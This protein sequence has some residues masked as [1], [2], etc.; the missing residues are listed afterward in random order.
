MSYIISG[1]VVYDNI[2]KFNG[3]FEDYIDSTAIKELN[4][5]LPIGNVQRV[6]GGTGGNI[7]NI[8]QQLNKIGG[9]FNQVHSDLVTHIGIDNMEIKN[10]WESQGFKPSLVLQS[11]RFSTASCFIISS[12]NGNQ[13]TSFYAGALKE[14]LPENTLKLLTQGQNI[15]LSPENP[16]NTINIIRKNKNSELYFDPGQN[17]LLFINSY[18]QDLLYALQHIHGLF[19]N[20]YEAIV[21]LK[22][23]SQ[24]YEQDF[25]IEYL[26]DINPTL[27]FVVRTLGSK[28]VN[29]YYKQTSTTAQISLPVAPIDK[30]VDPTGCGDS[31]RAG[32]FNSYFSNGDF[33]ESL[34]KGTLVASFIAEQIG[35]NLDNIPYNQIEKRYQRLINP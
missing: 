27:K 9:I 13:I 8:G 6:L 11:D 15:L 7:Y 5:S 2:L 3:K 28:G 10:Y 18:K 30:F 24:E 20:E 21:L 12:Q 1:S 32:F 33:I 17:I 16:M 14:S 31:F 22:F 25:K 23:L 26:F 34:T 19:I 35:C 29:A 4:V